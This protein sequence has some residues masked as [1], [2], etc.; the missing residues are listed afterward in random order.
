M[1]RS[2]DAVF[3]N[4]A[5]SG[6]PLGPLGPDAPRRCPPATPAGGIVAVPSSAIELAAT[7]RFMTG[8]SGRPQRGGGDCAA[9]PWISAGPGYP[10]CGPAEI[11]LSSRSQTAS[12]RSTFDGTWSEQP[13]YVLG[14]ALGGRDALAHGLVRAGSGIASEHRLSRPAAVSGCRGCQGLTLRGGAWSD[15]LAPSGGSPVEVRR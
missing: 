1:S 11:R 9:T 4:F 10:P 5:T 13:R 2:G 6:H 7:Q 3:V 8:L 12:A 15:G 14:T